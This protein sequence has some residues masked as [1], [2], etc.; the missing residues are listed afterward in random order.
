M[1]KKI[2]RKIR[3]AIFVALFHIGSIAWLYAGIMTATTLN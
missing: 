2:N 1:K 3:Q